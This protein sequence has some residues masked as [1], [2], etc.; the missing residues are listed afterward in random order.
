MNKCANVDGLGISNQ[1]TLSHL[2]SPD[3]VFQNTT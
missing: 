2:S 3:P 1:G